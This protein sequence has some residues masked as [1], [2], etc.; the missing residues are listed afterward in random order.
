MQRNF[1]WAGVLILCC[2]SGSAFAQ[3]WTR[4]RGPNGS[5]IGS[6]PTVPAE[7]TEKDYNWRITLPGGGHSSP[8]L[9]G[10]RL[11]I[12]SAKD[13]GHTRIL[14]CI[15]ASDGSVFW[16]K[17]FPAGIQKIHK[18]SSFASSTPAVDKD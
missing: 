7:F 3:E 16:T 14:M 4:F 18:F 17:E 13:E 6:A 11:F 1:R 10:N 9:W 8:V 5:G 2:I 15:N 12:T